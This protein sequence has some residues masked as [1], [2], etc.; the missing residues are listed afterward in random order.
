MD[1]DEIDICPNPVKD[2][3]VNEESDAKDH[4][5]GHILSI[6]DNCLDL[7]IKSD[8]PDSGFNSS[9]FNSNQL[10]E[11]DSADMEE[12]GE[13]EE[14]EEE[15]QDDDDMTDSNEDPL[16]ALASAAL[17]ASKES[18]DNTDFASIPQEPVKVRV[19]QI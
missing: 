13:E 17:D 16:T 14:E 19:F 10:S 12:A 5:L 3:P 11:L 4:V 15:E 2:E 8:E 18:N 6:N 7:N 9:S 1:I